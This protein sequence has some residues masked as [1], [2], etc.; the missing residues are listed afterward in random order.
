MRIVL[1]AMGTDT[2]PEP[3]VLAAIEAGDRWGDPILLTGPEDV[4]KPRLESL[5]YDPHMVKIIHAPEVLEMSD[6]PA[7]TA[8]GKPENSMAV[9][10]ELLKAGEAD[11]FVTAGNTGGAM[12]NALFRLGRFKG[13]KRPALGTIF[14]VQD[15]YAII[16]DIGANTDCKPTYLLQFA[17]FGSVYAELILGRTNPRIG[18]VS[19]GEEPGKGN[20]LVKD[21][22]PIL[23]KANLNFVGNL[24]PKEL[25]AG[26]A[27]VAVTDGFTG[28]VIIKTS[29]AVAK[30]LTDLLRTEITSRPTTAI[31]GMLA[32]PAFRRVAEILDPFEYGA[33]PL[34]GVEGLVFIGHG[35]SDSR[36]L[37]NSIRVARDAVERNLL[38][39]LK[40]ALTT[41]I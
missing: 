7:R 19:N 14:P 3:E 10:M 12:A 23:E 34:L 38:G 11:A 33:A 13:V 2:H 1:D 8:R 21:T 32:R 20:S 22:F 40:D 29:E 6:K 18:L 24:E 9:G 30:L 41:R 5:E 26:H 27:D 36:A 25:L 17:V 28:N 39:T 37:V 4:L 35:R 31:G 16:I 15:G